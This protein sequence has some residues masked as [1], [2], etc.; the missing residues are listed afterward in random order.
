MLG[1]IILSYPLSLLAGLMLGVILRRAIVG[2]TC[3]AA[4]GAILAC[5]LSLEF[6]SMVRFQWLFVNMILPAAAICVVLGIV[7]A[8][9]GIGLKA[10]A[11]RF[12]PR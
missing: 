12:R 5:V 4:V 9:I 11:T 3:S 10:I 2:L 1:L 8:G 6:L 7:G